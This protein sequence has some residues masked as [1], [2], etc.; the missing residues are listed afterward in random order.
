MSLRASAVPQSLQSSR[1]QPVT[2][3]ADAYA[4]IDRAA[5]ISGVCVQVYVILHWHP[6]PSVAASHATCSAW[7][8]RGYSVVQLHSNST[9]TCTVLPGQPSN[10][11]VWGHVEAY[12][13]MPRQL[14]EWGTGHQRA[15][16]ARTAGTSAL[17]RALCSQSLLVT[18]RPPAGT[19]C[20]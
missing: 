14:H 7:P 18:P 20:N 2:K 8:I 12:P 15:A 16:V 5:S 9:A 6:A 4:T 17:N 19:T 11:L 1:T 10:V 13:A 3:T